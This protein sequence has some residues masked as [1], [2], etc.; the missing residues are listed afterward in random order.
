VGLNER[1]A[2]EQGMEI[3]TWVRKL[4]EVDRARADG[5]DEGFVK[6]HTKKGSDRIV[7]AT[8]VARHA[9]DLISEISVAM[10]AG[11]GLGRLASVIHPY[12]TQAEAIRQLGDAYNRTRLTP[13]AKRLLAL[14]LRLRR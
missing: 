2:A 1:I 6:I 9:G 14:I 8:V 13:G 11:M 3:A 4:D 12:P 7:G 10:A 5:D